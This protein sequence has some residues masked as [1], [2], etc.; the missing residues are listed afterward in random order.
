M[1]FIS[2]KLATQGS[3]SFQNLFSGPRSQENTELKKAAAALVVSLLVI[4]LLN[5]WI[6]LLL[7]MTTAVVLFKEILSLVSQF[8]ID[9]KGMHQYAPVSA[10]LS[11]QLLFLK[12][13]LAQWVY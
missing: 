11:Q 9:L 12:N 7:L 4:H 3:V 13:A 2:N 10:W 5:S 8:E 6:P 1:N